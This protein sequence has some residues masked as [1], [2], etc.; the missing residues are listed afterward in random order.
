VFDRNAPAPAG[1][2]LEQADGTAW[3]G[4]FCLNMLEIAIELAGI[5]PAYEDMALK[6]MEHFTWIG[7]AMMRPSERR[8]SMWDEEDG[9]FYDVLRYPDGH[10]ESLRIRSFVGLLPICATLTLSRTMIDRVPAATARAIERLG[11]I[12]EIPVLLPSL[13]RPGHNG[14]FIF[15]FVDEA[16]LRR[17]LARL[18]DEAEFFSP[19]G[20]RSLSKYHAD[21]PF[22]VN[23]DGRQLCVGY[24]PADSNLPVFG[25]NSN[26]RGPVWLLPNAMIYRALLQFY[27]YY[28]DA[29]TIECP[30]GSGHQ[31][32]LFEV[33]LELGRR[34]QTIFL[35]DEHGRRPVF[36]GAEKFQTDPQWRDYLLFY[37]FF[38]GD[39]GAGIGASHQTGWTGLIAFMGQFR[40][41]GAERWLERGRDALDE[42]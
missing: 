5:D 24:L 2:L 38:H 11:R 37:E 18:L 27:R 21:H 26:W 42:L 8:D 25:G 14:S 23:V 10:G 6:F 22:T 41:I 33:A 15:T 12:A 35:P 34:L 16:R 1:G 36:G 4:F 3:M 17:V 28:G 19:Y 40:A 30:T 7:L 20:V 32:T 13:G 9:F 39:N 31:L 29:F